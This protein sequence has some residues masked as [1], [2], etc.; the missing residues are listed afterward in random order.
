[1]EVWSSLV[2]WLMWG[3]MRCVCMNIVSVELL[4]LLCLMA[5]W[6]Y[7]VMSC[8]SVAC[9]VLCV[10][11]I[12][13]VLHVVCFIMLVNCLLNAFVICLGVIAVLLLN[14]IACVCVNLLLPSPCIV[15]VCF[16]CSTGIF[17]VRS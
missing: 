1:M 12:P 4:I 9:S 17:A 10:F 8:M 15:Y 14:V 7:N 13:C 11:I 5:S 16:V 2:F 3:E 6:T